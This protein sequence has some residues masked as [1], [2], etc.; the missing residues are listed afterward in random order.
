MFKY[1]FVM[2]PL[3][4]ISVFVIRN[5]YFED[6]KYIPQ[7][8]TTISIKESPQDRMVYMGVFEGMDAIHNV[9][10]NA[11]IVETPNGPVMRFENF[12]VSPGPDLVVYLSKNENITFNKDLGSQY[13]SLGPL[14]KLSGRQEYTLPEKYTDYKSVVIWCRAFSILFGAAPIR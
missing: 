5:V 14:R 4:G 11:Y 6:V 12:S 8:Q 9:K 3:V 13:V 10:G 7:K 2:V 1:A